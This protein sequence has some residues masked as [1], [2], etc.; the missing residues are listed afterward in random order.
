MS[1]PWIYMYS[2]SLLP[3]PSPPEAQAFLFVFLYPIPILITITNI[4]FPWKMWISVNLPSHKL[5]IPSHTWLSY[6]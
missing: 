2:P 3:P 1:Q 6:G 4:S 5:L